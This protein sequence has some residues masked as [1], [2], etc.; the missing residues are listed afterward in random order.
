MASV[1]SSNAFSGLVAATEGDRGEG[2]L[3]MNYVYV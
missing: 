3:V 2:G 1:W